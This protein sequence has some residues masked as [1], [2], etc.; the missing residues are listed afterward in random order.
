M[1]NNLTCEKIDVTSRDGTLI[2]VVMLY[3]QRFYSDKSPWIMLSNGVQSQKEDLGFR[4][5]LL[6]LTD[7]GIVLSFPMVRGTC[8]LVHLTFIRNKVLRRQLVLLGHG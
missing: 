7:R 4:P 2:P 6:S 8:L 3:D 1:H 5:E